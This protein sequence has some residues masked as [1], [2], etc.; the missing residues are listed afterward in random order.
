MESMTTMALE[1]AL[2]AT[3]RETAGEEMEKGNGKKE[4]K[5]EEENRHQVLLTARQRRA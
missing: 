3:P 4:R 1:I 2:A 5:R